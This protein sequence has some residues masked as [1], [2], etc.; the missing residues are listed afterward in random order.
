MAFHHVAITTRDLEAT[1]AFYTEAMEFELVRA[2]RAR[3]AARGPAPVVPRRGPPGRR[4]PPPGRPAAP[5]PDDGARGVRGDRGGRRPLT[6]T[7]RSRSGWGHDRSSGPPHASRA[8]RRA[9][10]G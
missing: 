10:P 9:P 4:R 8:L 5:P 1:H 2:A 6:S 7:V 3:G